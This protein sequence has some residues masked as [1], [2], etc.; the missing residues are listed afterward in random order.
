MA[1]FEWKHSE[2]GHPTGHCNDHQDVFLL[3]T[4]NLIPPFLYDFAFMLPTCSKLLSPDN[5]TNQESHPFAV[6]QER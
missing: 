3:Y 6:V 4:I 1:T 5:Q 2:K